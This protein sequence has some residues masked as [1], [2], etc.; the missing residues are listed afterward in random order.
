MPR[1]AET[2]DSAARHGYVTVAK[3]T[4]RRSVQTSRASVPTLLCFSWSAPQAVKTPRGPV[5][6]L[7]LQVFP[8]HVAER[9]HNGDTD[10]AEEHA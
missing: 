9:L 8:G 1:P 5:R 10:V 2:A 3:L 7:V 4:A 6:S